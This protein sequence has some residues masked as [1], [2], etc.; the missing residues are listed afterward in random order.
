VFAHLFGPWG[1]TAAATQPRLAD[2]TE[3]AAPQRSVAAAMQA[4]DADVLRRCDVGGM[5][6]QILAILAASQ[7]R[8]LSELAAGQRA[9]DG[10]VMI[11][12]MS[13]VFVCSI[14]NRTLGGGVLP[15]LAGSSQP[16]DFVSTRALANL[17]HRLRSNR[18]A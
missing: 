18:A 1:A 8:S 17:L 9:P 4:A 11:D 14:I 7:R 2:T 6:D 5:E 15:R 3:D 12:S 10:G 16:G 13:A